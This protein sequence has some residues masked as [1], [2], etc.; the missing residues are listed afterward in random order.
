M[1]M[2]GMHVPL[3]AAV[4]T[5]SRAGGVPLTRAAAVGVA[6]AATGGWVWAALTVPLELADLRIA[7][8]LLLLE[9]GYVEA[10]RM[11]RPRRAGTAPPRRGGLTAVV[12]VAGALLLP[13]AVAALLPVVGCVHEARRLGTAGPL[14]RVVLSAGAAVLAVL[15]V[16]EVRVWAAGGGTALA[17]GVGLVLLAVAVFALVD[18]GIATAAAAAAARTAP[19]RPRRPV[20]GTFD[21]NLHDLAA[22]GLGGLTAAAVV[23]N[24]WLVPAVFPAMVVMHRAMLVPQLAE[25]AQ[26]DGKTGL[27]NAAT[28]HERAVVDL[29][30]TRPGDGPRAVLVVDLDHFKAVNDTYGHVAGDVVLAAVADAIRG[31]VRARDLVGRFGGE[32]F[33]VLLA[34]A[35]EGGGAAVEQIA[36]RIRRT[37]AALRVA[38]DTPEGARTVAGLRVSI[39]AGVQRE[40]GHPAAR[41]EL[42]ELVGIADAAVYTAKRNGRDQVRV[43][44]LTPHRPRRP[45]PVDV[46]TLRARHSCRVHP[47]ERPSSP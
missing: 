4:I 45:E 35:D 21:D 17:G 32:E 18:S 36:Q 43:S 8:L 6:V 14:H 28:W 11:A 22:L 39:G 26:I 27:L 2:D 9:I 15:A 44:V 30:A 25:D 16:W 24:P 5:G 10:L 42:G 1:A 3:R 33:V 12:V 47:D 29:A 20:L 38:I 34:R 19:R 23:A 40:A 13:P 46:L 7:A 31:A 41:G 37:V